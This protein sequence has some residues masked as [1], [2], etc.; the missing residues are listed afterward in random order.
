MNGFH[1]KIR[2]FCV[3]MGISTTGCL[4]F[5]FFVRMVLYIWAAKEDN[6][7]SVFFFLGF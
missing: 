3:A 7:E 6:R 4:A 1:T 2:C 5:S